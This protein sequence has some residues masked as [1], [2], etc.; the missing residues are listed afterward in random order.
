MNYKQKHSEILSSK[1]WSKLV[2]FINI[3]V[4]IPL[5][6]L[7]FDYKIRYY[8]IFC[9]F[10]TMNDFYEFKNYKKKKIL[11][12][13]ILLNITLLTPFKSMFIIR[14]VR[15][16]KGVG[17]NENILYLASI[18]KNNS[19][20]LK[21]LGILIFFYMIITSLLL[22]NIEPESFDNSYRNAFYWSGIMLTTVGYGDVYPLSDMGRMVGI[23]SSLIGIGI[24]AIPAGIVAG[25]FSN[26]YDKAKSVVSNDQLVHL[27]IKNTID[28]IGKTYYINAKIAKDVETMA[29][30][31]NISSSQ[32][33]EHTLK[34]LLKLDIS[35]D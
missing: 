19:G 2:S 34:E 16:F 17:R 30:N 15:I 13:N 25:E 4:I 31:K 1:I 20:I 9:I 28:G 11:Y 14:V 35:K 12:F 32:L 27:D 22:F 3:V 26:K 5:F 33:V 6:F 23:I 24:V 18:L 7:D 10:L 29:E 8:I 21:Q